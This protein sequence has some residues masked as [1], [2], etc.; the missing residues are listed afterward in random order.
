MMIC[1]L[2]KRV[3]CMSKCYNHKVLSKS[4]YCVRSEITNVFVSVSE[5]KLLSITP[6]FR[7]N[8]EDEIFHARQMI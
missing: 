6:F 2:N 4:A 3:N 5:S 7:A 8:T 1:D